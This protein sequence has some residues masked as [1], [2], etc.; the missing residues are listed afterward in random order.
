MKSKCLADSK[1]IGNAKELLV[2]EIFFATVFCISSLLLFIRAF[3]GT[4]ITDE[5]FYISDALWMLRGN[6]PYSLNNYFAGVGGSFVLIPFLFVFQKLSPSCGGLVLY[7][8]VA[9]IFFRILLLAVTY[10][11]LK[12]HV[13]RAYAM[14]YV[15]CLLP[16]IN[17][18][19][20]NFSYNTVPVMLLCPAA[21]ML[22]DATEQKNRLKILPFVAA[23]FLSGIAVFA[24]PVYASAE[25]LFCFLILFCSAR[26]FRLRN[27]IFFCMG[28]IAEVILVFVPIIIQTGLKCFIEGLVGMFPSTF[29]KEPLTASTKS[30]KTIEVLRHFFPILCVISASVLFSLLILLL[31]RKRKIAVEIKYNILLC[32]LGLCSLFFLCKGFT[33]VENNINLMELGIYASAL[34]VVTFA[35]GLQRKFSLYLFLAPYPVVFSLSVML[36]SSSNAS[37]SRF[38]A[39]LPALFAFLLLAAES[40][41]KPVRAVTILCALCCIILQVYTLYQNP[42]R[43][44]KIEKL[45]TC[46]ESGV[47]KGLYTTRD[48]AASLPELERYLNESVAEEDRFSFRDN[49]PVGY[50]MLHHGRM[51]D[52][53]TWDALQYTYGRNTP[54]FLIDYYRRRGEIPDIILY[55][56]YGR[57]PMLSIDNE[58]FR[59][60][61]FVKSYYSLTETIYL[62]TLFDDIRIY[63][64]SNMDWDAE[65]WI[66][67]FNTLPKQ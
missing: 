40:G 26:E 21:V 42:Y 20:L 34:T 2:T 19:I 25:I 16:F 32:L 60:N 59:Y 47:F 4:D 13:K 3:F 52:I 45:D 11:Y 10:C 55:V 12:K 54:A 37:V 15:T 63:R 50:L 49:V 1:N 56:D 28:G 57:D 30:E 51:C 17:S 6:T 22:Y 58:G 39:A 9:F 8:R 14:M 53:A 31:F 24:H 43:D 65:F 48:R 46:V 44:D 5:S 23:G 67:A 61:S 66:N 35:L 33:E 64:N 62:N 27:L 7:T 29:P 18:G 38:W 41:A 36:L